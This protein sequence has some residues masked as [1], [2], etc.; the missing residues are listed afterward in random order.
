MILSNNLFLFFQDIKNNPSKYSAAD[1]G[2]KFEEIF[3]DLFRKNGIY[4]ILNNDKILEVIADKENIDKID[5]EEFYS[6]IKKKIKNKNDIEILKNDFQNITSNYIY[7]PNG[8]QEFPDF[9]VF[10]KKYIITIEIKFSKTKSRSNN[11]KPMWNS[12]LPKANAIYI[13]GVSGKYV[14]FFKGDDILDNETR[15]ELI[16]YFSVI[17]NL[18][19]MEDELNKKLLKNKNNFGF[20]PYIRIAYQHAEKYSTYKNEN[21]KQKI[22]SFFG[23]NRIERENKVLDFIKKID[24]EKQ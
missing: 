10:Y 15:S 18:N 2:E 22:E 23:E 9:L 11:E 13:Y 19:D 8:S 12:N 14:T 6:S 3:F 17:K 21:N 20:S 5:A 24:E 7:Q 16:D 1:S 4:Q